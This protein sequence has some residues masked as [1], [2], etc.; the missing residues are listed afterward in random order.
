[1]RLIAPN[2]V[3]VDASDE[4]APAMLAHGFVKAEAPAKRKAPAKKRQNKTKE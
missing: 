3:P 2:G 1:M 4:A